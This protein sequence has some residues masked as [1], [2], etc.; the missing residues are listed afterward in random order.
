[1]SGPIQN[2]ARAA[3]SYCPL[4]L[5]FCAL[6]AGI[7]VDRFAAASA[8]AWWVASIAAVVLWIVLPIAKLQR[9]GS[10]L[11]LVGILCAGGAWHHCYWRLYPAD[12]ISRMAAEESRPMCVEAIAI[13]S[14]RWVPAPPPT[15]LR[16]IPQGESS[17]LLVWITA[18][19]DG[20]S[21]QPASGWAEI[22]VAGQL[23]GVTA[24]DR[25]RVMAQASRP[26]AP[27][28]RAS[29]ISRRMSERVGWPAGCSPNRR[30]RSRDWQAAAIGHRGGCWR[31]FA[32]TAAKLCRATSRRGGRCWPQ[33]CCWA[34]AS[35]S[36]RSAMKGIS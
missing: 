11:L 32:L 29:L 5:V 2:R 8:V 28:I 20:R 18:V 15:P 23:K 22:N 24:G 17:E 6:V 34:A 35:S 26:A 21:F 13:T 12:E 10:C 19:R 33:P 4:A 25:V 3:P 27:L 16:V 30:R 1:M 36:I 7:V 9:L 14:P 31:T